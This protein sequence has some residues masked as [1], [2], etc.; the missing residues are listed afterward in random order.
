MKNSEIEAAT[1]R[2]QIVEAFPPVPFYG[3]ITPADDQPW[4]EEIDDDLDLRDHLYGQAWTSIAA[5]FID[6]HFGGLVL[7]EPE[8]FATFVP[9][10]LSRGLDHPD[11]TNLVRA[12]AVYAFCPNENAS[13]PEQATFL[14]NRVHEAQICALNQ[15]Q[16]AV[17]RVFLQFVATTESSEWIRADA[18]K[19]LLNLDSKAQG[20]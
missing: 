2:A 6:R 3:V 15:L 7:M 13:L 10:W 5:E 14:L 17:V 16:R 11:A 18:R 8:A 19:A 12:F 4:A 20:E 9:A 1:I